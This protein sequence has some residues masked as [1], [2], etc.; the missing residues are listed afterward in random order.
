M[1]PRS[2]STGLVHTC[3]H[4]CQTVCPDTRLCPRT[5]SK[6]PVH[7][8]SHPHTLPIGQLKTVMCL[9]LPITYVPCKS[10]FSTT[11]VSYLF[12]HHTSQ[13]ICQPQYHRHQHLLRYLSSVDCM[14]HKRGGECKV[15][16]KSQGIR[17]CP[18]SEHILQL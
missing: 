12:L 1:L 10:A 14:S 15:F 16:T 8:V 5:F 9:E 17:T 4:C 18:H 3:K 2:V 13:P 6:Q 11:V 7:T